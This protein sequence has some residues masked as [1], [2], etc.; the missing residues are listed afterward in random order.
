MVVG[1]LG[2]L[3]GERPDPAKLRGLVHG[4]DEVVSEA[5]THL[6]PAAASNEPA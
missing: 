2:S 6:Q 4:H 1:Y 5:M 3:I